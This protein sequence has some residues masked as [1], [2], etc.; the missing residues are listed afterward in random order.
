MIPT[1]MIFTAFST[2][3]VSLFDKHDTLHAHLPSTGT[4]L[5]AFCIDFMGPK[6]TMVSDINL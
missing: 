2:S 6:A 4:L 3:Q 1:Y 5:G